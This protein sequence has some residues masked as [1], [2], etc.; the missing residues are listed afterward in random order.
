MNRVRRK[1]AERQSYVCP[2]AR[3]TRCVTISPAKTAGR[4]LMI[5]PHPGAT[6]R[7]AVFDL[8]LLEVLV[9]SLFD[10]GDIVSRA[11]GRHNVLVKFQLHR[12]RV[13]VLRGLD[14]G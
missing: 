6:R 1:G 8:R 2:V 10:P 13:S 11:L 4:E 9:R 14:Q 5:P 3:S 12:Q 7:A